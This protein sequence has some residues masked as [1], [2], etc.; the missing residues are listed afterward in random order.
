MSNKIIITGASSE[1]GAAIC[2]SIIKEGDQAMLQY[3]NNKERLVP[4]QERFGEDCKIVQVD[5]NDPEQLNGF[6]QKEDGVD[7]AILIMME[8]IV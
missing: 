6:D 1:I 3:C 8:V 4:L 5:F 7:G 2:E